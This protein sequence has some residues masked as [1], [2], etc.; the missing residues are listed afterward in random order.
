MEKYEKKYLKYFENAEMI[1]LMRDLIPVTDIRRIVMGYYISIWLKKMI[2]TWYWHSNAQITTKINSNN[3]DI[4]FGYRY[5][6]TETY[7]TQKVVYDSRY[8]MIVL[9]GKLSITKYDCTSRS[10][11]ILKIVDK[12]NNIKDE[13]I[14]LLLET[15][16]EMTVGNSLWIGGNGNGYAFFYMLD[17]KN[18]YNTSKVVTVLSRFSRKIKNVK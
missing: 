17:S 8:Y 6:G 16:N 4:I 12:K 7:T 14:I 1:F 5:R 2:R 11:L 9:E 18:E 13:P 15:R 10:D 3:N